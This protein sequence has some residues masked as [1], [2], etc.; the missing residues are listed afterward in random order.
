MNNMASIISSHNKK[1]LNGTDADGDKCNCRKFECPLNGNCLVESI[2][3]RADVIAKDRPTKVYF[4]LS[5]PDF[6]GRFRDHKT[7][8]TNDTRLN[9]QKTTLSKYIWGLRDQGVPEKD[10]QVKWSIHQKSSK[11]KCGSRRCDLCLSEKL[12]IATADSSSL[13][14]KRSELLSGCIHRHKYLYTK[15]TTAKKP[16]PKVR[17]K[18]H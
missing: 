6:K 14:N 4:G 12:A 5:E 8:I 17:K 16:D 13:L 1:V 15:V 3:Y 18:G 9:R 10:I 11:Y 2:I 7:S